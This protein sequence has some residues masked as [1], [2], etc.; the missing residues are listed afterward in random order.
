MEKT[1][2][3]L[4]SDTKGM[5]LSTQKLYNIYWLTVK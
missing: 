5:V 1:S 3:E 4:S 2:N